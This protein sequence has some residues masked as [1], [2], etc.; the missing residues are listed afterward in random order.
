MG[1]RSGRLSWLKTE[2][3][4]WLAIEAGFKSRVNAIGPS[5]LK[6]TMACPGTHDPGY[7]HKLGEPPSGWLDGGW[8]V[9][10]NAGNHPSPWV[11]FA[12]VDGVRSSHTA[13]RQTEIGAALASPKVM[14]VAP[15]SLSASDRMPRRVSG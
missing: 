11:R 14:R 4:Q 13:H 6:W 8:P 9:P 12:A 3:S 1:T 7:A 5:V 15:E 2:R 10:R